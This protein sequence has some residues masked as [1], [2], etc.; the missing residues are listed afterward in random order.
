MNE[1]T[2]DFLGRVVCH[3]LNVHA[4]FRGGDDD[5][6]AG[7]AIHQNSEVILMR[8]VHCLGDHHLAHQ[9]TRITGLHR[10]EGLVEHFAC[11]VRRLFRRFDQMH[12][13]FEAIFESSL[14]TTTRM[15]LR[16]DHERRT[17]EFA[18]RS[19]RFRGSGR[20]LALRAGDLEP[21]KELFRLI[22]V[23]VHTLGEK[24]S[25]R[26]LGDGFPT[27]KNCRI[28]FALRDSCPFDR[29]T[30]IQWSRKWRISQHH[31]ASPYSERGC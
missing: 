24:F 6:T 10:H 11:E 30:I 20:H 19:L 9:T 2:N 25:A 12:A 5:W 8:D 31:D 13:A 14:A 29:H 3:I 18:R 26:K 21:V 4:T 23:D 28:F 7:R 22:F 17:R 16:L 15:N 27:V 1:L